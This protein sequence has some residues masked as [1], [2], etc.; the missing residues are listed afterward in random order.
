VVERRERPAS[1]DLF[2]SHDLADGRRPQVFKPPSTV[3][4]VPVICLAAGLARKATAAAMSFGS[5]AA[6]SLSEPPAS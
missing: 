1:A 3:R 4:M 6:E 2:A 5:T